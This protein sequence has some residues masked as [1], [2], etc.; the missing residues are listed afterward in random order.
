MNEN[1]EEIVIVDPDKA[2]KR[3]RLKS[4]AKKRQKTMAKYSA[5]GLPKKPTCRHNKKSLK[6]LGLK[7]NEIFIFHKNFYKCKDKI[8][9][10]NYIL[11]HIHTVAVKRRRPRTSEKSRELTINY[12]I[13]DKNN[14]DVPVCSKTFAEVLRIKPSRIQGVAKRAFHSG[15]VAKENRG[16]DRKRFAFASRKEA[17][18]KFI[19]NF[20]PL[21]SHYSRGCTRHR[22]YLSP[23]LNISKMFKMYNDEALPDFEVKEGFFRKVFNTSFNIGF[24]SPRTDVCST[25]LELVERLKYT[26]DDEQKQNI[27]IQY[28]IHRLR[29]KSFFTFLKDDDPQIAI[30][31]FD[32]QKNLPLP[33]IPD[34]SAYYSRQLYIYNFTVVVGTSNDPLTPKNVH[35]YVWTEDQSSKGSNEICSAVFHCLNSLNLDGKTVIRMVADGCGGQNKNSMIVAMAMK[36]LQQAPPLITE[37]QLIFPVTGHSF[38]PPD[39]VFALTEKK[40]REKECIAQPEEYCEIISKHATVHYLVKEVPVLDW[41]SATKENLKGTQTWHFQMSKCK[42]IILKRRPGKITVRGELSYRSDTGTDKCVMKKNKRIS[43]VQPEIVTARVQVKREKLK[44]VDSLLNKHYGEKWRDLEYLE[45]YKKVLSDQ[46]NVVNSGEVQDT[47]NEILIN[48]TEE[49]CMGEVLD[50][51]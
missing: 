15:S 1:V 6:C 18:Q 38:I 37:V 4:I 19:Q 36:W 7:G 27:R 10:D 20:V 24:G 32:C 41:R 14:T 26:T 49:Y 5:P 11:Q 25:C 48:N 28:R 39:R 46:E 13:P 44:D 17:V 34:Q 12:F 50:F 43:L 16:G 42:R 35:A 51:V 9:Q 3:N 30:L 22:V 47:E 31:S 45:F 29:A 8:A 33:K 2:R 23:D 21:E 40:I